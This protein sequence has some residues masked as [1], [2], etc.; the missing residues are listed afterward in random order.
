MKN[1]SCNGR[2]SF[3][4]CS[5][6][7]V[8]VYSYTGLD[9]LQVFLHSVSLSAMIPDTALIIR[10][11]LK[12]V[13]RIF[14]IYHRTFTLSTA[15]PQSTFSSLRADAPPKHTVTGHPRRSLRQRLY[16]PLNPTETT[17]AFEEKSDE[18][19]RV[20]ER[21][22]TVVK[23]APDYKGVK[24]S[25]SKAGKTQIKPCPWRIWPI[26]PRRVFAPGPQILS[27]EPTRAVL[28]KP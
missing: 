5:H 19:P 1:P 16:R 27:A 17:P 9:K 12:R 10:L 11:R 14:Y 23:R 21:R 7:R 3:S 8:L 2:I 4:F 25:L 28:I 18:I 22:L 20:S 6:P 15:F 26:T 24:K 13:R